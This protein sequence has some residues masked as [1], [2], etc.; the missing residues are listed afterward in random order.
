MI[1]QNREVEVKKEIIEKIQ[2]GIFEIETKDIS[3][4]LQNKY[5]TI[6]QGLIKVIA[7][8]VIKSTK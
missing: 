8:R 6:A 2:V 1:N 5:R 3:D 7:K 4:F